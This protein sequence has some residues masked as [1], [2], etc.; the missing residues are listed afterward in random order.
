MNYF[1]QKHWKKSIV[2]YNQFETRATVGLIGYS[3]DLL[4]IVVVI[5]SER[6]QI[7]SIRV[8]ESVSSIAKRLDVETNAIGALDIQLVVIEGN[9]E[10]AQLLRQHLLS[11]PMSP[12]EQLARG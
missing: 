4:S 11:L 2:S 9:V 5:E 12:T 1:G 10:A 3:L 7:I 8:R 6:H